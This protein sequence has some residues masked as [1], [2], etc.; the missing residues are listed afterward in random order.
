MEEGLGEGAVTLPLLVDAYPSGRQV[1]V[2]GCC[3]YPEG[4]K[5]HTL[6]IFFRARVCV[7]LL[8]VMFIYI[9]SFC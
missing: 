2:R 9:M 4:M 3:C 7:F 1:R 5:K 8:F 6:L